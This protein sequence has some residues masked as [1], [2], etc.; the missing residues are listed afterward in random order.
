VDGREHRE[1]FVQ[2]LL[3]AIQ[4][5]VDTRLAVHLFFFFW[6]FVFFS[7]GELCFWFST[8]PVIFEPSE[9]EPRDGEARR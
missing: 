4:T 6:G 1:H 3:D 8:E 7:L 2:F 9:A 5:L